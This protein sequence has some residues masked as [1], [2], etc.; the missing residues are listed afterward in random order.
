MRKPVCSQGN[1]SFS[2]LSSMNVWMNAEKKYCLKGNSENLSSFSYLCWLN[3]IDFFVN[4]LMYIC[5]MY[6]YYYD[7]KKKSILSE[8]LIPKISF[9]KTE[10]GTK[11][12]LLTNCRK[13]AKKSV[14]VRFRAKDFIKFFCNLFFSYLCIRGHCQ[15]QAV[16]LQVQIEHKTKI[17]LYQWKDTRFLLEFTEYF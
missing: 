15:L 7:I 5:T 13:E 10:S 11:W 9:S 8:H 4:I 17:K 12:F 3:C 2:F 16:L 14:I 6:I 1:W